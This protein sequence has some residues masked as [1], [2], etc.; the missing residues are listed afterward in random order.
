MKVYQVTMDNNSNHPLYFTN[1]QK[2]MFFIR[3]D[4][5]HDPIR[6][7]IYKDKWLNDEELAT[8]IEGKWKA[9][10]ITFFGK[11]GGGYYFDKYIVNE[12]E[13]N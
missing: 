13:V 8:A 11:G 9:K 7:I 3:V 12:I 1:R 2:C 6:A 10:T 4:M 5:G